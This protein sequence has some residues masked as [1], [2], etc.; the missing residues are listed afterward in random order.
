MTAFRTYLE[1]PYRFYLRHVL[2]LKP[3]D[4]AAVE[5]AANQ[6][7][8]LVHAAVESFGESGD[9]DS[10]DPARIFESLRAS[11]YEYADE[12]Y[13]SRGQSAVRLQVRQAER[14][15]R[16]VA[17]EQA[18]RAQQG[19]RIHATERAVSEADGAKVKVGNR[20]IGLRGRFDRID[21]HAEWDQWAILDYKTHGA[22]PKKKHLKWDTEA[23]QWEWIDLQLPLYR[24][25]APFLGINADP[26]TVQL[27]YF[28]VSDKAVETRVNIAD[29]DESLMRDAEQLIHDCVRRILACDFA[30]TTERV[31]FDDYQMILQT[32]V[33][34]RLLAT[35]EKQELETA[36]HEYADD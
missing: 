1:C 5:L 23:G 19:W 6:F 3:V 28:N 15:L 17:D 20:E 9:R 32:G 30:P 21:Y 26:E 4:D 31:V 24:M 27:G 18:K 14:R 10:T 35:E 8:D 13:G 12:R 11:L 25:M 33:A 29:F 34:S 2:K 7:G 22:T 36:G 16:F